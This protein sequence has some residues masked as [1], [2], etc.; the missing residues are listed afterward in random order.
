MDE[1]FVGGIKVDEE[2]LGEISEWEEGFVVEMKFDE[3]LV[4]V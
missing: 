3:V 2:F 4:F 1:E